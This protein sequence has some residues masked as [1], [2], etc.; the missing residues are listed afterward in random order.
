VKYR[1]PLAVAAL[2]IALRLLMIWRQGGLFSDIEYD[3]GVHLGSSLLLAHGHALYRNQVFLQPP[4]ISLLLLPFAFA[5]RWLGEA[6]TFGL[7]RLV[8]VAVS[9]AVAG[10][11]TYVVQRST[12]T[13]RAMLAGTFAAVFAPSIVAGSTLMLE[14]WLGLFGIL[15]VERITRQG[16]SNRNAVFAGGYLGAATM[17]KAWG[18]IPLVAMMF[19]LLVER[20]RRDAAILAATAAATI[21]VVIGPFLILGGARLLHDVV[22]TQLARPPDG[23]QGTL[24]RTAVTLGLSPHRAGRPDLLLLLILVGVAVLILRA[25]LVPGLA[26]LTAIVLAIALPVFANAPSFFLHYGDFFTPWAALL[27]AAQ[28]PVRWPR[29]ASALVG[30]CAVV[31]VAGTCY[32]SGALIRRQRAADVDLA[33]LHRVAG[34]RA[35]VVSD[36]ASLLILAG[37]FD[38]PNCPSWLDARGAALT[39]LRGHRDDHFYPSGFQRLPQWQ[40]EYVGVMSHADVLILT[41]EPNRHPEWSA[42]TSQWVQAHFRRVAM[43][44]HAGPGRVPIEVWRRR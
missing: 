31:A 22:T 36:Q 41:G 35:C 11:A 44:G 39:E 29:Q 15:A 40:R 24:A 3:D 25:L 20:R 32:R 33:Q 14:P 7:T 34:H 38:R 8:T 1:L 28:A 12:S 13:R 30:V 17:V 43:V 42:A 10:L 5:A 37:A 16:A 6:D 19:W 21:L 27:I 4:G 18:A 2:A 26:R 9:A 23:V